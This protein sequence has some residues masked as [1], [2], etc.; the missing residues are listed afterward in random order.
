MIRLADGHGA[1]R[2][3]ALCGEALDLNRLASGFLRERLRNGIPTPAPRPEVRETIPRHSN[4]SNADTLVMPREP[5]IA[6]A[7][8]PPSNAMSA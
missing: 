2:L 4:I 8:G 6:L 7:A 1:D 3:E 5:P